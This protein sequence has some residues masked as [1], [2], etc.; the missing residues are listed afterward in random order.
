LTKTAIAARVRDAAKP[1]RI[2]PHNSEVV[3]RNSLLV[4][5]LVTLC[6][7]AGVGTAAADS[8]MNYTDGS[9]SQAINLGTFGTNAFVFFDNFNTGD[10]DIFV[11]AANG[12]GNLV[13]IQ[14]S[15][16]PFQGW[17]L[18]LDFEGTQGGFLRYGVYGCLGVQTSC[19]F[20]G[21]LG[22]LFI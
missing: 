17:G 20:S 22:T 1:A 16:T 18:F 13:F 2:A 21:R 4:G 14:I 8:F 6:V 7:V 3:M 5:L 11:H 9:K 15:N 12:A 19:N 10:G